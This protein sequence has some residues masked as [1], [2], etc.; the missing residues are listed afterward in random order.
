MSK[1]HQRQAPNVQ[2]FKLS[3]QVHYL[4]EFNTTSSSEN[5]QQMATDLGQMAGG[6][7]PAIEAMY[8]TTLHALHS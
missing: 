3:E 4:T 8:S 6:D 2:E 7:P 5:V 1:M